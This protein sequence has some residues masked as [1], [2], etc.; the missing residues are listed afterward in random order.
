MGSFVKNNFYCSMSFKIKIIKCIE[1]KYQIVHEGQCTL[2]NRCS[3]LQSSFCH[4][5]NKRMVNDFLNTPLIRM[6]TH[7]QTKPDLTPCTQQNWHY[8][9]LFEGLLSH[10]R[11]SGLRSLIP[12]FLPVFPFRLQITISIL[13]APS[14]ICG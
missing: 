14:T 2:C 5:L 6:D 4:R 7:I 9:I 1:M 3:L 11:C 10:P 8:Q 12:F 13:E